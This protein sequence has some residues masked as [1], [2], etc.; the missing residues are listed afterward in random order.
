MNGEL[1][2][3]VG[4]FYPLPLSSVPDEE[5]TLSG[6]VSRASNG[7]VEGASHASIVLLMWLARGRLVSLY[8]REG[9]VGV[10]NKIPCVAGRRVSISCETH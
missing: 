5:L 6:S 8:N 1:D 4:I 2:D 9:S 3:L 10:F 7:K